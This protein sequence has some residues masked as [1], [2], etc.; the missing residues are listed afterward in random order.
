M[1]GINKKLYKYNLKWG[2]NLISILCHIRG[3]LL[4]GH[5]YFLV[6][7][8]AGEVAS[9]NTYSKVRMETE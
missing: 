2:F 8:F 1:S 4:Q 6:E 3:F 7:H 9:I 5:V